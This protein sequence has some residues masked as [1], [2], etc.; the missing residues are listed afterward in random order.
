MNY[1]KWQNK[2]SA[3]F[4]LLGIEGE[5]TVKAALNGLW[6]QQSFIASRDFKYQGGRFD[7]CIRYDRGH[8]SNRCNHF[9]LIGNFDGVAGPLDKED[10]ELFWPE[11]AHLLKWHLCSEGEP[12]HYISNTLYRAAMGHTQLDAAR[13]S[14]LWPE[15]PDELLLGP[16]NKLQTA[17]N[18]RLPGLQKQFREDLAATG[19]SLYPKE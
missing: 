5:L 7:I 15:A 19:L 10:C 16:P 1:F 2:D 6:E 3:P 8:I 11:L 14:C 17:L 12:M 4:T 9:S 18:E 13:V